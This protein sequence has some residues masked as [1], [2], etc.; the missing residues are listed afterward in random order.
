MEISS[1]FSV[2]R[3]ENFSGNFR[4]LA[5]NSIPEVHNSSSL[6]LQRHSAD[7]IAVELRF[8]LTTTKF[9]CYDNFDIT[10]VKTTEHQQMSLLS[11]RQSCRYSRSLVM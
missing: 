3:S 1:Y 8:F 2:E 6:N 4:L 5:L 11:F 9:C 7:A 10:L